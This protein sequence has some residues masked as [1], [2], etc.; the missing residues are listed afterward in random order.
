MSRM[1]NS[2]K[3]V[4]S[5]YSD[6]REELESIQERQSDMHSNMRDSMAFEGDDLEAL[7]NVENSKIRLTAIRK[8]QEESYGCAC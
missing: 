5:D 8:D 4:Y 2:L 3:S 7:I 1:R 6:Q